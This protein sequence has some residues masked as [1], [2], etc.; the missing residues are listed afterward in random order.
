M[1]IEGK[2]IRSLKFLEKVED[3]TKR[4][5]G[6]IL[7]KKDIPDELRNKG[8]VKFRPNINWGKNSKRNTVGEY[9]TNKDLPKIRRYINTIEWHWRQYRGRDL[10]DMYEFVDVYRNVYQK[11]FIKPFDIDFIYIEDRNIIYANLELDLLKNYE[12]VLAAVNILLEKFGFCQILDENFEE[13]IPKKGFEICNWE[14]LPE[15]EVIWDVL[16]NKK[17]SPPREGE[18]RKRASFDAY[19]ITTFI[20]KNPLEKY[21]G[22]NGFQDYLVFVF[23]KICVLETNKYGN[24][25]YIIKKENWKTASMLTKAQLLNSNYIIDRIIHNED[26]KEKIDNII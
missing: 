12:K 21:V 6:V 16:G 23:D 8:T 18:R 15:G 25:T 2:R 17:Y 24:A 1:R 22:I 5:V 14:I 11:D 4:K 7:E 3:L 13:Y 10:E 20:N 26:W 9:V 19:R